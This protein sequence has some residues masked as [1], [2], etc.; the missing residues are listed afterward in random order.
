MSQAPL[1]TLA[2]SRTSC[3]ATGGLNLPR[4]VAIDGLGM[5]WVANGGAAITG[6][7]SVSGA[8]ISLPADYPAATTNGAGPV[9]IAINP[10]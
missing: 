3:L 6:V 2:S 1:S 9:A 8:A 7:F 10:H 4:S 5:T